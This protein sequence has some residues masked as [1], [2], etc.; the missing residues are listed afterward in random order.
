MLTRAAWSAGVLLAKQAAARARV[1]LLL[2]RCASVGEDVQVL[3]Q[4]WVHGEGRVRV[5]NG[6]VLDGRG[7][8]IELHA[9]PGA[10]LVIGDGVHIEPGASLEAQKRVEVGAH[11]CI[12][13]F[14]KVI[15]NHFHPLSGDRMKRPASTAVVI[16]EEVALGERAIVLPGAHLQRGAVIGPGAVVSRRVPAGARFPG[17]PGKVMPPRATR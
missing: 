8:P 3:G 9:E 11:A 6:V 12:G 7:A 5:G 13:R 2:W 10:E 14:A 15:D 17:S 4:V 1:E 16:E